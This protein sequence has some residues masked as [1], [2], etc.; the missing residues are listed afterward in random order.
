MELS[1]PAGFDLDHYLESDQVPT[2][3]V[4]VDWHPDHAQV[5]EGATPDDVAALEASLQDY[6]SY[7]PT[8]IEVEEQRTS[9]ARARWLASQFAGKTP[10]GA[11]V[12]DRECPDRRDHCVSDA[13]GAHATTA[14]HWGWGGVSGQGI[15]VTVPT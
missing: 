9:Q 11:Y 5:D 8:F 15:G 7:K 14:G 2:L 4:G 1:Y 6:D 10:E 13:A 12:Q 3:S